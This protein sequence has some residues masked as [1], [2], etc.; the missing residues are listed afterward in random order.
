MCELAQ[1]DE[2]LTHKEQQLADAEEVVARMERELELECAHPGFIIEEERATSEAQL[3]AQAMLSS[4]EPAASEAERRAE[5]AERWL[6]EVEAQLAKR[7]RDAALAEQRAVA[8]HEERVRVMED[9][10]EQR[11][12]VRRHEVA[13]AEQELN[14]LNAQRRV[15]AA[16]SEARVADLHA[17]IAGAEE[18]LRAAQSADTE[19][20]MVIMDLRA[21]AQQA[22]EDSEQLGAELARTEARLQGALDARAALR[23]RL[24]A[25]RVQLAAASGGPPLAEEETA[26]EGV[27]AVAPRAHR[28]R[29]AP[30]ARAAEQREKGQEPQNEALAVAP[31]S[32]AAGLCTAAAAAAA[33]AAPGE[34]LAAAAAAAAG[35]GADGHGFAGCAAQRT[36]EERA[37]WRALGGA[38]ERFACLARALEALDAL[39]AAAY[40]VRSDRPWRLAPGAAGARLRSAGYDEAAALTVVA[41]LEAGRGFVLAS[42]LASATV[43]V[44][45]HPA[46]PALLPLPRRPAPAGGAAG[47]G[48][49]FS[50]APGGGVVV[51]AVCPLSPA[52][53]ARG[54]AGGADGEPLVRVGDEV[55]AVDGVEVGGPASDL[56]ALD[57]ETAYLYSLGK[58]DHKVRLALRRGGASIDV[59]VRRLP[60][61]EDWAHWQPARLVPIAVS[62]AQRFAGVD[63]SRRASL[64]GGGGGAAPGAWRRELTD[65]PHI[66]VTAV[67]KGSSAARSKKAKR[68]FCHPPSLIFILPHLYPC[69]S[70]KAL[71][72]PFPISLHLPTHRD[73]QGAAAVRGNVGCVRT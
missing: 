73:G 9:A 44:A 65:G 36:D 11:I 68:P 58:A 12:R 56:D 50:D 26:A 46:P 14:A 62:T 38:A 32:A 19:E 39:R 25:A 16:A 40:P 72:P 22:K 71:H 69:T 17:A 20:K 57:A 30:A 15:D 41:L 59:R 28:V 37:A 45:P 3:R 27:E 23:A 49:R 43:P 2:L 61:F 24:R 47:I 5:R 66:V 64:G 31:G 42:D 33:G 8:E 21:R 7:S 34:P 60:G 70:K 1:V 67:E 55:V 52:A 13:A 35:G 6:A 29:P 4:L 63:G 10:L 48:V 53:N 18:R 54:G 51:A